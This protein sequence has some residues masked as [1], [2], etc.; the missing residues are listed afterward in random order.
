MLKRS[1][2]GVGSIKKAEKEHSP[3]LVLSFPIA[4][5]EKV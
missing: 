3:Y 1:R 5:K 2:N 4:D